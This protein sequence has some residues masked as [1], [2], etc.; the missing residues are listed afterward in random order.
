MMMKKMIIHPR[1]KM[2]RP[3]HCR[4]KSDFTNSYVHSTRR[5]KRGEKSTS[6]ELERISDLVVDKNGKKWGLGGSKFW[7]IYK[8]RDICIFG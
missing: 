6:P 8:S 2:Q 1:E 7:T 5:K 4:K 3:L